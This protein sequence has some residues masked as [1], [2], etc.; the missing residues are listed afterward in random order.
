MVRDRGKNLVAPAVK[1]DQE[2]RPVKRVRLA[3]VVGESECF[4]VLHV[5]IMNKNRIDRNSFFMKLIIFFIKIML[6]NPL[7]LVHYNNTH[8]ARERGHGGAGENQ[9]RTRNKK[10]EALAPPLLPVAPYRPASHR[11][12]SVRLL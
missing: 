11:I 6:A 12:A 7:G 4:C 5:F 3:S 1:D 2:V 10:G 8:G 9:P